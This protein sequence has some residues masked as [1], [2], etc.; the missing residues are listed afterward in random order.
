[1]GVK[2]CK[3]IIFVYCVINMFFDFL[4]E[5]LIIVIGFVVL[6]LVELK[7]Y[8]DKIYFFGVRG[9]EK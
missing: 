8:K 7:L 3:N 4:V 1:M 5:L 6:L 9:K 2:W